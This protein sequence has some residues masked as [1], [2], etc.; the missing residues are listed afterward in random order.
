MQPF[1]CLTSLSLY[2]YILTS[3]VGLSFL[4][5]MT[6]NKETISV[7]VCVKGRKTEGE[8]RV[9]FGAIQMISSKIHFHTDI[10]GCFRPI[11]SWLE[12]KREDYFLYHHSFN[13]EK[14]K[15]L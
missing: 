7:C 1:V 11:R 15:K 3:T 4:Y 6:K 14:K 12:R 2:L 13:W 8:K 5:H 9:W 10:C